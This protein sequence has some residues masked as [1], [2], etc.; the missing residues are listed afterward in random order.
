MVMATCS[1]NFNL[2]R[3]RKTEMDKRVP[4]Q[5]DVRR[6]RDEVAYKLRETLKRAPSRFEV[7]QA[8][9]AQLARRGFSTEP[10]GTHLKLRF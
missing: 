5:G 1:N 9:L 7:R 3:R 10:T 6:V 2:Y 8:L 4:R